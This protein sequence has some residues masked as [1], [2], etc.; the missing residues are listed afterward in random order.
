[1]WLT[2]GLEAAIVLHAVNN[3]LVFVP[4]R[5]LGEGAADAAARPA[6]A[7][8]LVLTVLALAGYV[9]AGRA[10]RGGALRPELRDRRAGPAALPTRG[11][12]ATPAR[13][14]RV[15]CSPW[16]REVPHTLGVWGNWQPD[17]F[18]FR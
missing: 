3:V 7:G 13:M 15:S 18:W 10:L 14:R 8:R 11:V 5:A 16:R 9:A 4:G 12:L 6:R 17:G 2:G 1:M